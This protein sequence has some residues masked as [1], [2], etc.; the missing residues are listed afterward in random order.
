MTMKTRFVMWSAAR[1]AALRCRSGLDGAVGPSTVRS[2]VR[3][4]RLPTCADG[5]RPDV[6]TL[7]P[8][9]RRLRRSWT[10]TRADPRK[11]L[12]CISGV[13]RKVFRKTMQDLRGGVRI[14]NISVPDGSCYSMAVLRCGGVVARGVDERRASLA[15]PRR[16]T[17][18]TRASDSRTTSGHGRRRRLPRSSKSGEDPGRAP[19]SG[20]AA[21]TT[22]QR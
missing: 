14:R 16:E 11:I 2:A 1:S 19:T 17:L 18:A 7:T 13:Q 10:A 3:G 15:R 12:R 4:F 8:Q 9:G 5:A 6:T 22:F 20:A 21:W